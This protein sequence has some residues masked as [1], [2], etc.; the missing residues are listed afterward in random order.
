[1]TLSVTHDRGGLQDKNK[2][3][4]PHPPCIQGNLLDNYVLIFPKSSFL[5]FTFENDG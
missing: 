1:M 5:D 3:V 4:S 2:F